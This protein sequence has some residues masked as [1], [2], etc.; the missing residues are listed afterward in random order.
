M[1]KGNS[2][3]TEPQLAL[4]ITR[5]FDAPRSLLFKMWIEGEHLAHWSAPRGFTIPY[6]EADVRPGGAW[7]CCMRSPEGVEYWVGGVYRE[8]V[9]PER[10]VFTHAFDEEEGKPGPETLVTVT[11]GADRGKTRLTFR[12]TGF[13]S[14]PSRDGH[15]EGWSQCF[16]RLAEY[17]KEIAD[18]NEGHAH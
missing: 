10:L 13:G 2:V 11:F 16:D 1:P 3:P 9:E 17:L 18:R 6:S 14:V 12:Q 8:I 4:V 7:R 5:V 15:R